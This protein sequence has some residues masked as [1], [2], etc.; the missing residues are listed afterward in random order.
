MKLQVTDS[1]LWLICVQ[2]QIVQLQSS[3]AKGEKNI[4][5]PARLTSLSLSLSLFFLPFALPF[6]HSSFLSFF[7]SLRSMPLQLFINI[8]RS[9]GHSSPPQL[10]K[11]TLSASPHVLPK[12]SKPRWALK[13]LESSGHSNSIDVV[14]ETKVLECS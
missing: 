7:C 12:A 10:P 1:W 8:E 5:S 11:G 2:S 4:C 9:I 14:A 13:L 6:V 3:Y